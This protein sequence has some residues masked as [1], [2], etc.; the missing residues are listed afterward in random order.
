M[1]LLKFRQFHKNPTNATCIAAILVTFLVFITFLPAL[2]NDFVN[3]DDDLYVYENPSIRSIDLNFFKWAFTA[4][5][6]GLW[7]PLTMFS[8]A[9]DYAFWGLDPFGYHLTNIVFHTINTL[10]VFILTLRLIE[11]GGSENVKINDKT[12][13]AGVVTAL[14]FGLHPLHVESVVWVSER[15]DVLCAFFFLLTILVHLRYVSAGTK[16]KKLFY[17]TFCLLLFLLALMSKPMAVSLPVVLLILDFY[18]IR[19]L[20]GNHLRIVLIEKAPFF[21]LSIASSLITISFHHTSGALETLEKYPFSSRILVALHSYLFYLAKAVFPSNLAPFYS[22]PQQA[23]VFTLTY[24][25]TGIFFFAVIILCILMSKK[26]KIF[27]TVWLYY[28]FTL[29]PTIG[30]VKVGGQAAADRYTYLPSLGPFLLVG[31]GAGILFQKSLKRRDK[32]VCALVLIALFGLLANRTVMQ[33]A[34]WRGSITLW[35]HEIK[36]YPDAQ[37]AYLNR[38]AAFQAIGS[39]KQ[40]L[41]DL[42]RAIELEPMNA[43]AY[44]NRG[45]VYWSLGDYQQSINDLNRAIELDPWSAKAYQ[46][47]GVTYTDMGEYQQAIA[48]FTRAIKLNSRYTRAY[49][50]RG[51]AYYEAGYIQSALKDFGKAVELDPGY[52]IAYYSLGVIYSRMG[53]PGLS[54]VYYSKAASLGFK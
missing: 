35:T 6:A 48:D 1:A 3:W 32:A 21:V 10:L 4:E 50:N 2:Q 31:V 8:L 33:T 39:Y 12:L 28:V 27:Q 5:V 30:V 16:G 29:M 25:L 20:S 43:K 41:T 52:S 44:Q 36:L 47:R 18:P 49:Y 37:P 45:A 53:N 46:N 38:G 34:I 17:Y 14:L 19:R 11:A 22:Y 13:I 24:L 54:Q 51:K 26:D 7:H 23:E 15:K 9:V 40:S 42:T